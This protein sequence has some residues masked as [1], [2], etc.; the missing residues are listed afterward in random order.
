MQF[1]RFQTLSD[2]FILIGLVIF[3]GI[4]LAVL[5][6]FVCVPIFHLDLSTLA[7]TLRDT[8]SI[9]NIG[10][11]KVFNLFV[12]F[13]MWVVSA[14]ILMKIRGYETMAVWQVR[15]PQPNGILMF[16][17]IVFVALLFVSAFLIK[18]N[19]ALPLP[20]SIKNLSSSANQALMENFLVMKNVNQLLINLLVIGLAPAL[21]EEIF[22]RGTLQ[23]LLI[24]F[25]GN[26]HIGV[27]TGS[28]IFAAIHLNVLQFIPMLFLA[29]V[30]GYVCH[31]TK[32]IWPGIILH[33]LNNGVAVLMNYYEDKSV[34]AKQLAEDS[35]SPS[36]I[37]TLVSVV[38]IGGFFYWVIKNNTNQEVSSD[39]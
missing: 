22:F 5:G 16:L 6:I 1:N 24:H 37:I 34:L 29:L 17:P 20:E 18:F 2:I 33:F 36:A 15:S 12:S 7:E 32:S 10:F 8:G 23:R 21:F 19:A 35:Y 9:D 4:I 38:I 31:Y 28:I 30:L 14:F 26:A 27:I 13:G 3:S 39:E 25:F 11:I